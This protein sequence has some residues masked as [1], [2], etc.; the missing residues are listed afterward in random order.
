M[1]MVPRSWSVLDLI[2]AMNVEHFAVPPLERLQDATCV[3]L[4]NHV[5]ADPRTALDHRCDLVQFYLL[6]VLASGPSSQLPP[7]LPVASTP[8]AL[9]VLR[10]DQSLATP[11][12]PSDGEHSFFRRTIPAAA[13]THPAV[14][15]LPEGEGRYTVFGTVEG[16]INR[17]RAPSWDAARCRADAIASAPQPGPHLTGRIVSHPLPVLFVPQIVSRS[18]A[19][20]GWRTIALDLRPIPLGVKAIEVRLGV[21]L[22]PS[23]NP[24]ASCLRSLT[25]STVCNYPFDSVLIHSQPQEMSS[26]VPMQKPSLSRRISGPSLLDM[27]T[28]IRRLLL[29]GRPAACRLGLLFP[30]PRARLLFPTPRALH[31]VGLS[32]LRCLLAALVYNCSPASTGKAAG[33][34]GLPTE[35]YRQ[36]AVAAAHLHYPLILKAAATGITPLLWK[37]ALTVAIP[38]PGKMPDATSGW[39]SIAL[40]DSAAKGLG[41]ALR[42]QLAR[43]LRGHAEAGQYGALPGDQISSPALCVQSY[44]RLAASRHQSG[45]VLFVDGKTAYYSVIRQVLFSVHHSDDIQLLESLFDRLGFSPE[46]QDYL[47]AELR[48]QGEFSLAG[49]PA[50]LQEFFQQSLRGTWFTMQGGTRGHPTVETKCGTVPGTPLADILFAF[51]QARFLRRLRS[52]MRDEGLSV[53]LTATAEGAPTPAWADDVAI[54]LGYCKAEDLLPRLARVARIAEHHSR[55][56]G[57]L[58]NFERG[59]T[60]A[61]CC[62]RGPGSKAVKRTTLMDSQP[63]VPVTLTSGC[64]VQL[65]IVPKYMHLGT[66]VSWC[67][68]SGDDIRAKP[69]SAAP[70]FRRLC[71]TLLRNPELDAIEKTSLVRSL[72]SSLK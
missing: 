44:F 16:A 69:K 14:A 57:V 30:T 21:P 42:K 45:A 17:W 31:A 15:R 50:S 22:V 48:Q 46:E 29:S 36:S 8:G 51:A 23:S 1:R 37:G 60:E 43:H 64:T 63:V 65:R 47:L 59:K 72:W 38:K 26:L 3:C 56:S 5:V 52:D 11:L 6:R 40:F 33:L 20:S 53:T 13:T 61:V 49:V 32:R 9:D 39:R 10:Q 2:A 67:G 58:L 68:S 62:F 55:A 34:S 35:A 54:M 12:A 7:S 19:S 4:V 24:A 28:C 70:I 18:D 27:R 41:R 71:R 25:S 66:V